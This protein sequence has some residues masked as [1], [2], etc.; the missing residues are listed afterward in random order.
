MKNCAA[1][2]NYQW[3]INLCEEARRYVSQDEVKQ[4]EKPIGIPIFSGPIPILPSKITLTRSQRKI[5]TLLDRKERR[6]EIANLLGLSP[7]NLRQQIFKM[8]RKYYD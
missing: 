8:K 2:K 6:S 3:C 5:V 1:C 4:R 7:V